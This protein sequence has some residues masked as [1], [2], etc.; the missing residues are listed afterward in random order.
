VRPA[1]VDERFLRSILR[2]DPNVDLVSFFI[3]RTD[4][5]E[6]PLGANEMSLIPFR[7]RRSSTSNCARSIC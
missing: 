7:I 4:T 3:L 2:L 1:V 5:D 6:L